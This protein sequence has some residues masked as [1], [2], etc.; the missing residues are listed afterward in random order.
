MQTRIPVIRPRY[1]T[2]S[3]IRRIFEGRSNLRRALFAS[4]SY[5][6]VAGHSQGQG[7]NGHHGHPGPMSSTSASPAGTGQLIDH[8]SNLVYDV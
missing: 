7:H 2:D 5:N 6:H 3:G 8:P 1:P 4:G